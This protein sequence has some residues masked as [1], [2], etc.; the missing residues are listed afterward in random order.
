MSMST[1]KDLNV[2]ICEFKGLMADFLAIKQ[3]GNNIVT[4]MFRYF[5][6]KV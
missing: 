5:D 3:Y 4:E 1:K 2:F 6:K